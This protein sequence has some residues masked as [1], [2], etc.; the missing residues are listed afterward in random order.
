MT[1]PV[2][3]PSS[4]WY[5]TRRCQ[6]F[7]QPWKLAHSTCF[8]SCMVFFPLSHQDLTFRV[9]SSKSSFHS[10]NVWL[11]AAEAQNMVPWQD[12]MKLVSAENP[13][14]RSYNV[15][16]HR[17]CEK[18]S[19]VLKEVEVW[20]RQRGF[21]GINIHKVWWITAL[22]TMEGTLIWLLLI[23]VDAFAIVCFPSW[24]LQWPVALHL[25]L[26]MRIFFLSPDIVSYN[27]AIN[28]CS[29]GAGWKQVLQIF[30]S[31]HFGLRPNL[32]SYSILIS[33]FNKA[34]RWFDALRVFDMMIGREFCPDA[35]CYAGAITSHERSSNWEA[36]LRVFMEISARK[37][38]PN[39]VCYSALMSSF[40]KG[41]QWQSSLEL[42]E[43]M[44]KS[45]VVPDVVC[46]S[47]L[48]SS[49]EK[50]SQWHWSLHFFDVATE[51][52]VRP[53]AI[54]YH[55]VI[56]SCEKSQK[57]QVAQHFFLIMR[58]KLVKQN[59]VSYNVF[60]RRRQ[61]SGCLF[62]DFCVPFMKESGSQITYTPFWGLVYVRFGWARFQEQ[63]S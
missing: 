22:L 3:K 53:N 45:R 46:Y 6:K 43:Q 10:E 42:F 14:V 29:K 21:P 2:T 44:S 31:Q 16:I 11:R 34:T 40:E 12:T 30:Q 20:Q 54:S 50:G 61:H 4:G 13:S 18:G 27:T 25:F 19:L 58:T 23:V 17:A 49:F 51:S 63:P 32:V 36:A 39:V 55:A 5:S 56:S 60:C 28:S 33:S 59:V 8:L 52:R 47:A 9:G 48:L 24:G 37:M 26:H 57:W 62:L 38:V 1:F 7:F 41:M 15:C 35:V